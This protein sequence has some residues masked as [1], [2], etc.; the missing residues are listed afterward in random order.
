MQDDRIRLDRT[1]GLPGEITAHRIGTHHRLS[2]DRG[3]Q[4]L[5]QRSSFFPQF[6]RRQRSQ[7][8]NA[9]DSQSGGLGSGTAM[10]TCWIC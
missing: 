1:K 3:D 2:D 8:A 5:S 10:A 6:N 7:V 9:S 4:G